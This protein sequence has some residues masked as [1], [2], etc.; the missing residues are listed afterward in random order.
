MTSKRKDKL[1]K[2]RMPGVVDEVSEDKQKSTIGKATEV[3]KRLK[4]K[5]DEDD[6][7]FTKASKPAQMIGKN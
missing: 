5:F 4:N 6:D 2:L 1:R 3:I 7:E